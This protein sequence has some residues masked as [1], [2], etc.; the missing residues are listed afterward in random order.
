MSN[1]EDTAISGTQ[2]NPREND[3][4]YLVWP[5]DFQDNPK[6]NR[7]KKE[8]ANMVPEHPNKVEKIEFLRNGYWIFDRFDSQTWKCLYPSC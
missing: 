4:Q 5:Y 8:A 2:T 7:R 6:M 3:D 1:N